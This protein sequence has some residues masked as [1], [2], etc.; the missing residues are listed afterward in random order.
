MEKCLTCGCGTFQA[1]PFMP[2]K[3]MTCLHCHKRRPASSAAPGAP[4]GAGVLAEKPKLKK[5]RVKK[6]CT[7]NGKVVASKKPTQTKEKEKDKDKD[8]DKEGGGLMS[9]FKFGFGGDKKEKEKGDKDSGIVITGPTGFKR[10]AHI[11]YSEGKGF[12]TSNLPPQMAKLFADLDTELKAQ[13]EKPMTAAEAAD[14]M[15]NLDLVKDLLPAEDGIQSA[16]PALTSPPQ[17]PAQPSPD[18]PSSKSPSSPSPSPSSEKPRSASVSNSPFLKSQTATGSPTAHSRQQ[19]YKKPPTPSAPPPKTPLEALREQ[20]HE[21]DALV[22]KLQR[23]N[24]QL[25]QLDTLKKQVGALSQEKEKLAA[26]N[27]NLELEIKEVALK[28]KFGGDTTDSALEELRAQLKELQRKHEGE[29]KSL[30]DEMS[31]EHAKALDS[32]KEADG[33][34]KRAVTLEKEKETLCATVRTRDT[35]LHELRAKAEVATRTSSSDVKAAQERLQREFTEMRKKFEDEL[36]VAKETALK[37][38]E[39]RSAER[40]EK[41]LTATKADFDSTRQALSEQSAA[42]NRAQSELKE[43]RVKLAEA[44]TTKPK[45]ATTT[46]LAVLRDTL[47]KELKG[48]KKQHEEDL[49]KAKADAKEELRQAADAHARIVSQFDNRVQQLNRTIAQLEH[50]VDRLQAPA[51]EAS[52]PPPPSQVPTAP[53]PPPPPPA[54]VVAAPARLPERANLMSSIQQGASLKHVDAAQTEKEHPKKND[55]VSILAAALISRRTEMRE[56]EEEDED[57]DW[58][59]EEEES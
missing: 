21:K 11:A 37:E 38:G 8:K 25:A 31:R 23:E 42:N 39:L 22:D 41:Q 18:R 26:A 32:T 12:E 58:E 56:E 53:V 1:N 14:L 20:L 50:E 57:G 9:K 13:G 2:E 40:V 45:G 59:D 34:K 3:C 55:M 15:S 19:P 35:E 4:A 24:G 49:A 47:D 51:D 6:K 10:G 7:Q 17:R 36:R 46:E 5:T 27:R 28:A 44:S 30:R 52:S 54:A 33:L 43:L 16:A 48:M 29:L